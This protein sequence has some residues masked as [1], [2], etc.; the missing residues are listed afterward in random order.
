[1]YTDLQICGRVTAYLI[2]NGNLL[3]LK[4][5]ALLHYYIVDVFYDCD[6]TIVFPHHATLLKLS[7][8]HHYFTLYLT[9]T[10]QLKSLNYPS[11]QLFKNALHAIDQNVLTRFKHTI[12]MFYLENC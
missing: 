7:I 8:N 5:T 11:N 6:Q 4:P 2:I 3:L 1:M 9:L 12:I 10:S